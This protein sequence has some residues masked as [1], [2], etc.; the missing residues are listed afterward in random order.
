MTPENSLPMIRCYLDGFDHSSHLRYVPA[1]EFELWRHFMATQHSR[2]VTVD[3]VSI[4]RPESPDLLGDDIDFDALEPVL[5][6]SFEKPGPAGSTL[7]VVRFLPIETYPEA[8]E[9][10]LAHFDEDCLLSLEETPGYFVAAGDEA[11]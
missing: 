4:W 1:S 3:E 8:K 7:P 5:R 6:V 11:A 9:A 2:P 10:L